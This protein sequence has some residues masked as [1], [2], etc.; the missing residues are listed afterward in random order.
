M[1]KNEIKSH[2]EELVLFFLSFDF[3][4]FFSKFNF[5]AVSKTIFVNS[6][7]ST[8]FQFIKLD[9]NNKKRIFSSTKTNIK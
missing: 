8:K 1:K 9:D 5:L 6:F 4:G 3:L 2:P 7:L